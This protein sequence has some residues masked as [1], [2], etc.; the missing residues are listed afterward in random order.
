MVPARLLPNGA[1]PFPVTPRPWRYADSIAYSLS[2]NYAVLDFAAR[3]RDALLFGIWRMGRNSIERGSR[4]HWTHYP[5]RIAAIQEA[6]ARDNPPARSGAAEEDESS[7]SAAGRRR[8]PARYFDDVLRK[9]E[10]RDA[11]GTFSPPTSAISRP[12]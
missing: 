10:L 9:P 5:R 8:I 4:D 1:T 7:A 2:L 3:H 6:H 12:R 11:R